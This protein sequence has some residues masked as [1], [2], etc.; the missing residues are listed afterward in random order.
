MMNQQASI[1]FLEMWSDMVSY[2]KEGV[3][4]RNIYIIDMTVWAWAQQW[5]EYQ[6]SADVFGLGLPWFLI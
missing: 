3:T 2:M 1:S 6:E 4:E 5:F